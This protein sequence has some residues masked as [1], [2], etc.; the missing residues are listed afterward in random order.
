M[1]FLLLLFLLF[2]RTQWNFFPKLLFPKNSFEACKCRFCQAQAIAH[3]QQKICTLKN[4]CW[5][6]QVFFDEMCYFHFCTKNFDTARR[7]IFLDTLVLHSLLLPEA[8]ETTKRT[9]SP[10]SPGKINFTA[11]FKVTFYY[12]W[13]K[14]LDCPSRKR[15]KPP[16]ILKTLIKIRTA[17]FKFFGSVFL[18][19][20]KLSRSFGDTPL[21]FI[22]LFARHKWLTS[23][24]T[25]FHLVEISGQLFS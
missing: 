18:W 2:P 23:V 11:F 9:R 21:F 4:F 12:G 17:L 7:N 16:E 5:V 6:K 13:P 22:N 10:I 14:S 15:Q 20:K 3:K 25:L 19:D 1:L 24:L 8:L